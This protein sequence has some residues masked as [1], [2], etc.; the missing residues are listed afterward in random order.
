MKKE[1]EHYHVIKLFS[2]K[3]LVIY[4][5]KIYFR[6]TSVVTMYKKGWSVPTR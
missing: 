6:K 3:S 2:I 1:F 4:R 5:N